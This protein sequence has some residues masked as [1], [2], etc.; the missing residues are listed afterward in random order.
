MDQV[1]IVLVPPAEAARGQSEHGL[2][3]VAVVHE[4]ELSGSRVLILTF[5]QVR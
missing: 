3:L 1:E 2:D 5:R 4:D